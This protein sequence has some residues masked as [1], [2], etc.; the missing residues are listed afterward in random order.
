MKTR[1]F[2][3]LSI[4]ACI[5]Y[6]VLVLILGEVP[7]DEGD[8][9]Q[10]FS[11]SQESWRNPGLFLDH[12]GKPFFILLTSGFAQ[13][14]FYGYV[15]FN[16]LVFL[17]TCL[18]A[19]KVLT[20]FN[21]LPTVIALFPWILVS[22]PDYSNCIIGGMTEPLFGCML[23]AMLWFAL[24]KK[25]FLFAL[26]ASFTPFARSE[27][28]L[29]VVAAVPYLL[30][31]RQWKIL[32]LLG[33]GFVGYVIAGW[34]LIDQPMWY[35]ENN[36]YPETSIYG[37]GPW[38]TYIKSS[39]GHLG[40]VPV[41]ILPFSLV[42]WYNI[43]KGKPVK[44][45]LLFHLLFFA[46]IYLGIIVIHSY[47]WAHGLRGALGLSRI[48]TLGLV[49]V[50]ALL[51]I[52]LNY[53]LEHRKM[54]NW[55]RFDILAC[56]CLLLAK[57]TLDLDLPTKANP[58]QAALKT[59]SGYLK[60]H[61]NEVGK[62]YYF[63]PLIAFFQGKTTMQK[64]EKYRQRFINLEKDALKKFKPGDLIVRDSKFGAADQG[65]PF[66]K[67][68]NYP[69]IVPVKRFYTTDYFTELNG[70]QKSVIVYEVMNRET[71]NREKWDREQKKIIKTIQKKEYNTNGKISHEYYNL[72]TT[73]VLPKL[74]GPKQEFVASTELSIIGNETIYLIFDDGKGYY[75]SVPITSET[76][77]VVLPFV[78][79]NMK[80]LLFV[81]NPSKQAYQLRLA[82]KYWQ[83]TLDPGIQPVK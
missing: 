79:G 64:D 45:Q 51:L 71:F 39:L 3:S 68:I 81:H 10:H 46:G 1:N 16:I 73:F 70:E 65:L 13:L 7:Q 72:D 48:A 76:Q 23:L 25:W 69:W 30:L 60:T 82:P 59:A 26:I 63:H 9:L 55:F 56:C 67:M 66:E 32:P 62:I 42:A 52:G 20:Y 2:T 19:K 37:S 54:N 40:I 29:V 33:A 41:I 58:L 77:E 57:E 17:V 49:P 4:I 5:T 21:V 28:M 14:G 50:I 38:Y 43:L 47:L 6:Y 78:T 53:F 15:C 44:Y 12:W 18:L 83:Q 24:N 80:G 61:E 34:L 74:I 36:P 35:F 75:L 27:G 22:I 31:F 11:I 8:G